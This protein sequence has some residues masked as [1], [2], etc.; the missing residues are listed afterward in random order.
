MNERTIKVFYCYG[1]IFACALSFI[2][3][4]YSFA[5]DYMEQEEFVLLAVILAPVV[6]VHMLIL[7]RTRRTDAAA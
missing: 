4:A 2:R 5:T 6:V 3:A 1:V 7:R